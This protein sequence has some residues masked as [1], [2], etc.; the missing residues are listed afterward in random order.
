MQRGEL[1]IYEVYEAMFLS[2]LQRVL[3]LDKLDSYEAK[4]EKKELFMMLMA[5]MSNCR[6]SL[7]HSVC[8]WGQS[9]SVLRCFLHFI[10]RAGLHW[11][12]SCSLCRTRPSREGMKPTRAFITCDFVPGALARLPRV[13][14]WPRWCVGSAILTFIGAYRTRPPL[15][16]QG[17]L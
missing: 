4:Q 8:K 14:E 1:A 10:P 11:F 15:L 17:P 6:M 9:C 5:L 13:C 3:Q 7:I 16:G 2:V 12:A